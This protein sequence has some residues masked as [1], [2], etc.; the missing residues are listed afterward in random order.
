MQWTNVKQDILRLY[1]LDETDKELGIRLGTSAKA[2]KH[3]RIKL[4]LD[5]RGSEY[6]KEYFVVQVTEWLGREDMNYWANYLKNQ[7]VEHII[8]Q[9]EN[10]YALFRARVGSVRTVHEPPRSAW[11]V[12]WK[13][14]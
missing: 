10:G 8:A 6:C 5:R 1:W 3:M 4:G 11:I 7:R 14:K 12:H 2:V 9:S 13:P